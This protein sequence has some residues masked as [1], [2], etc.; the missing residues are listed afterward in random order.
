VPRRAAPPHHSFHNVPSP[1]SSTAQQHRTAAPHSS[2]AQ[3]HRTAAPHSSTAQQHRTAT[4][5]RPP[6]H[7][8]LSRFVWPENLARLL[9]SYDPANWAWLG[10]VRNFPRQWIVPT[11]ARHKSRNMLQPLPSAWQTCPEFRGQRAFCGGAGFAMSVAMVRVAACVAPLCT[12]ECG[13]ARS[14]VVGLA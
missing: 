13:K 7:T 3:Q 6:L 2:T 1:H 5:P 14:V 9:S 8:P 12:G 10:Q 4:A 11:V